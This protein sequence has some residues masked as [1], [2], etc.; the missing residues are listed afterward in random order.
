M[1]SIQVNRRSSGRP[2]SGARVSLLFDGIFRGLRNAEY[3]G[4][5]GIAHFDADPGRG[6]VFVSGREA[7]R[8]RLAGHVMVYV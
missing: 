6:R 4:P 2:I 7:F 1:V 5:D 3:T 8:G